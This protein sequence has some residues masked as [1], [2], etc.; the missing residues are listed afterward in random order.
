LD[1]LV[2][3]GTTL[4]LTI[5]PWT[6]PNPPPP[7]SPNLHNNQIYAVGAG[8]GS[9]PFVKVYDAR[10][11]AL[12][13]YFL[14]YEASFTGGVRVAVGDVNGDGF[15]DIITGRGPG[16]LPEVKSFSGIDLTL[17]FDYYAFSPTF[18]GG[19]YVASGDVNGDR[20]EDI[21]VGMGTG[22][23][24]EVKVFGGTSGRGPLLQNFYAYDTTYLGGVTVGAS[25]LNSDGFADV[26]TGTALGSSWVKVFSGGVQIRSFF[27]FPGFQG[28]ITVAGGD[29][30]NDGFKDLIVGTATATTEVRVYS[31]LNDQLLVRFFAFPAGVDGV[32]VGTTDRH[33][34]GRADLLLGAGMLAPPEVRIHD[35]LSLAILDDFFAF[36]PAFR[37]GIYH[38]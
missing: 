10:T 11:S 29:V 13:F 15:A 35:A 18:L 37:G 2:S 30:T 4:K 25:D 20:Q 24:P 17:Q 38:G 26:I 8:T 19:I 34:N 36:D 5:D 3:D 21:I 6:T 27:A 33:T 1:G 32:R 12:K 31:G 22:G 23:L 7:P 9:P 28:G 14:A 16:G